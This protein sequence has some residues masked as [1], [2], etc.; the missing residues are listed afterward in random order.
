[1]GQ[2]MSA[3]T[4]IIQIRRGIAN[5]KLKPVDALNK[6]IASYTEMFKKI[7]VDHIGVIINDILVVYYEL[8]TSQTVRNGYGYGHNKMWFDAKIAMIGELM[9]EMEKEIKKLTL[10]TE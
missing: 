8:A 9:V 2:L 10:P 6:V 3:K 5:N 4:D 1:M 7:P